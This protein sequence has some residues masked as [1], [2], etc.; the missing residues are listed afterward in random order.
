MFT[1]WEHAGAFIEPRFSREVADRQW[2]ASKR[3]RVGLGIPSRLGF[4]AVRLRILKSARMQLEAST[5]QYVVEPGM[6]IPNQ[7]NSAPLG[8]QRRLT[9][10]P[11]GHCKM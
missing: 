1:K 11:A 7:S 5:D 2:T 4:M 9:L 8:P 10:N 6:A 3:T